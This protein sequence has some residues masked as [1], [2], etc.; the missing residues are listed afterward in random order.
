M[1][2]KFEGESSRVHIRECNENGALQ[3]WSTD[4]YGQIRLLT[5]TNLCIRVKDRM[6]YLDQ[7]F[8]RGDI[9]NTFEIH[10]DTNEISHVDI[11]GQRYLFG[12]R[13]WRKWGRVLILEEDYDNDTMQTWNFE[14]DPNALTESPTKSPTV[15]PSLQPSRS[16]TPLPS[17][18]P[19]YSP[20]VS[21][22]LQ[23]SRSPTPIPSAKPSQVPSRRPTVSPSVSPT[24]LQPSRSHSM[25]PSTQSPSKLSSASPSEA[26]TVKSS[27]VQPSKS[28]MFSPS[29]TPSLSLSSKPSTLHPIGLPSHYPSISASSSP[30][31]FP[32]RTP[33][34]APTFHPST[35]PSSSPSHSPSLKK[36]DL[37]YENYNSSSYYDDDYYGNGTD[38]DDYYG[39][40]TDTD[41][42]Y[43]NNG[44][45]YR[46]ATDDYYYDDYYDDDQ[47]YNNSISDVS[48]AITLSPE[49]PSI[50]PSPS[51]SFAPTYKSLHK[52]T[53]KP[54]AGPSLSPSITST[55]QPSMGPSRSTSL[56]PSQ[57][58]SQSP[59]HL[60]THQPFSVTKSP[61]VQGTR[62]VPTSGT[63]ICEL[64]DGKYGEETE[65][66]HI[67][68]YFYKMIYNEESSPNDLLKVLD[69]SIAE[70][71][72][73]DSGVFP[74]CSTQLS[75]GKSTIV[76]I[77][78]SPM[79]QFN[80]FCG[81]RCAV[82]EGSLTL[83]GSSSGSRQL[84]TEFELEDVMSSIEDALSSGDLIEGSTELLDLSFL[85][86][87][88]SLISKN[89]IGIPSNRTT[90]QASGESGFPIWAYIAA[91]SGAIILAV[92]AFFA[93][94]RRGKNNQ[95]DVFRRD[96]IDINEISA[97]AAPASIDRRDLTLQ[98]DGSAS[99]I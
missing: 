38:I 92:I 30:S 70:K 98:D 68:E 34:A 14:I 78:S 53:K 26:V 77:S 62:D 42:Y 97:D 13:E 88:D 5:E 33:S 9:E 96:N 90:P 81:P 58:P 8:E 25:S 63:D 72:I 89:S 91:A 52:E 86:P 11:D 15:S 64:R 46:N 3:M 7:C 85:S 43:F 32:Q 65:K 79:D 66:K 28:P 69:K 99:F 27:T 39:N 17:P 83:Y 10:P 47:D 54:S 36:N 94:R 35:S 76:G 95:N 24:T 59:S 82:V 75:A 29:N 93:I 6:L 49:T 55:N 84:S 71:V 44:T 23:P 60:L 40:G 50:R 80:S 67:V 74:Q 37:Y 12:L 19:S 57:Y 73:T 4:S 51:P 18:S 48:K 41:D 16:P 61:E 1:T 21:P 45:D 31:S 87:D 2:A 20:S 22:S 56:N